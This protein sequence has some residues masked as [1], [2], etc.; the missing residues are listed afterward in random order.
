MYRSF[1][2]RDLQ[3]V[4]SLEN[5]TDSVETSSFCDVLPLAATGSVDGSIS[6]WD[7]QTQRLRAT[8]NHEDAVVK[9]KFVKNSPMLATCSADRTVKMWDART[10]QCIKSWSGH[11]DTVLDIAVSDDGNVICSASDDG[12]C[13]VFS[14]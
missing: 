3:I 2:N 11:R 10:G 14:M 13:L 4:A 12:T 1:S 5:H 6:I 9:V 8:L 7:V